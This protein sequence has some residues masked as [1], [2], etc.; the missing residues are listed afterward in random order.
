MVIVIHMRYT[1]KSKK[2]NYLKYLMTP[3]FS[4]QILDSDDV[5]VYDIIINVLRKDFKIITHYLFSTFDKDIVNVHGVVSNSDF[6]RYFSKS[7]NKN[8]DSA[9]YFAIG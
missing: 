6:G 2:S 5:I 1:L 9:K 3:G 7:I 4:S 8:L